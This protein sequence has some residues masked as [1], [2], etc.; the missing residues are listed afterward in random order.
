[1]VSKRTY[2]S[3]TKKQAASVKRYT[4]Q[5][6]AQSQIAH[7][8]GVSKQRVADAQR[9]ASIG[10]R[11][12]S[13]FWKDVAALKKTG[14]SHKE[15]TEIIK[16]SPKWKKA[17]KKRTGRTR[18]HWKDKDEIRHK[19]RA[20]YEDLEETEKMQGIEYEGETYY[21]TPK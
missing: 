12:A 19:L 20:A 6:K 17:Y 2:K 4:K 3:L 16:F 10:K 21:D 14:Y 15:A 8:L 7:L 9:K 18:L 1:M 11:I 13:P 5:G